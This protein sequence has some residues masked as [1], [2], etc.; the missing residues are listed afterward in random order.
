[1]TGTGRSAGNRANT[2][3][4]ARRETA[5]EKEQGDCGYQILFHN[6]FIG[7]KQGGK[8]TKKIIAMVILSPPS[9]RRDVETFREMSLY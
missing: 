9:V 3:F 6:H 7:Y 8:S 4:F 2:F 1:M 5:C